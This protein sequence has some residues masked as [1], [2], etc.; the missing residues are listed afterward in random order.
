VRVL[1]QTLATST[2]RRPDRC[3]GVTRPW[4]AADGALVRL[5]LVGGVLP[6]SAMRALVDLAAEYGDGDV[7]LTKRA[8]LQLRGVPHDDGVLPRALVAG[9]REAGLLPSEA[10]DLVRNIMLSPLS[11]RVGGRADLR[12]V[13][14]ELDRLL[15]EDPSC[16]H[17]AGRFLFLLDDGRGDL[18]DR[19]SDLAVVAVDA[20][21]VQLRAGTDQWG[22][23]VAVADAAATVHALAGRF[24]DL[25]GDGPTAAWH[26]D[27]LDAPLLDGWRDERTR[28]TSG[29][30]PYGRLEQDDGRFAEHV[31]VPEGRLSPDLAARLLDRAGAEVVVTPW[32]SVLLP[33]LE[34]R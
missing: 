30:P 34:A 2:R 22:P 15:L 29:R 18:V 1:D 24:L 5:R 17:L 7:H 25:H 19:T 33:D 12:P 14:A 28:V 6:R 23:C 27:E 20:G 13:A 16:A 11:G 21:T 31:D 26:V 8:N 3:P 9:V 4:L 32:R 10:H